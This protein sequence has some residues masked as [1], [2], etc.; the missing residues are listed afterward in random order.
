[1]ENVLHYIYNMTKDYK[2]NVIFTT[3][4]GNHQMQ[5]YQYVKSHYP[6]KIISSGSLGVMGAGLPYA[7]GAQ[8]A[9]PKKTVI[10]IDGDSSFNMTLTDLKTIVENNLPIKI[11]IMNNDA[12]MMVTIWEKLFYEERYTATINKRNPS[13]TQIAESYGLKALQCNNRQ[14]LDETMNEFL[15]Y[16]D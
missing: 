14:K 9:N 10:C 4:V 15:N 6:K 13:F 7:I 16:N 12:Q 11:A 3:G 2:D 8:I 5:T 1:M